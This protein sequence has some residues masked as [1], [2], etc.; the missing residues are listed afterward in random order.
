MAADWEEISK[1]KDRFLEKRESILKNKV[2]KLERRLFDV[3]ITDFLSKIEVDEDGFIMNIDQNIKLFDALDNLLDAFMNSEHRA[4]LNSYIKD[5]DGLS[6]FNAKYFGVFTDDGLS[7][8]VRDRA[9]NITLRSIGILPNGGI[10]R[11]GYIDQILKG[12]EIKTKVK[13]AAIKAVMGEVSKIDFRKNL[14]ELVTTDET[15]GLF[16]KHYNTFIYDTYA[17]VDRTETSLLA[18]ELGMDSFFYA[19]GKINAS[20]PFCLARQGGYILVEEALKWGTAEDDYEKYVKHDEIPN[21]GYEN[22]SQGEF[23]G[24][25]ESYNP[26]QSMGGYRCIHRENYIPNEVAVMRDKTLKIENGKLTRVA[27]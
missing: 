20:R 14:K 4:L 18:K 24:K 22:H 7:K 16:Q 15:S 9:R 2:T 1:R 10:R 11:N 12:S 6:N 17:S 3:L 25:P 26:L 8:S 5:L 13:N 27:L 23:K 21:G 19:G